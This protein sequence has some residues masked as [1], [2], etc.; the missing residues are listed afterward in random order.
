MGRAAIVAE[1]YVLRDEQ[2]AIIKAHMNKI[3]AYKAVDYLS[4]GAS[5][6]ASGANREDTFH[7][8]S[9]GYG[10]VLSLQFTDYFSNSEVNSM[11]DELMAGNG[12]WDVTA[13]Q[14]NSMADN[15]SAVAGL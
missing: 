1:D 12:F 3:I 6:I 11:L 8:L 15:I 5:T 2:A 7:G 10:F 13:D 14:L 9:E 4:G